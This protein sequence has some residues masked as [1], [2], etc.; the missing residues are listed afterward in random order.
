MM[1]IEP[2]A[3]CATNR[4]SNQLSYIRHNRTIISVKAV[5]DNR[6][7]LFVF[8]RKGYK[9]IYMSSPVPEI[10]RFDSQPLVALPTADLFPV[11]D[12][13][14]CIYNQDDEP[15]RNGLQTV[16][17]DLPSS[18][19]SG[20]SVDINYNT[21]RLLEAVQRS[22]CDLIPLSAMRAVK[23]V[24]VLDADQYW[25][26]IG[27]VDSTH[28]AFN[29]STLFS[30]VPHGARLRVQRPQSGSLFATL[31]GDHCRYLSFSGGLDVPRSEAYSLDTVECHYNSHRSVSARM[32]GHPESILGWNDHVLRVKSTPPIHGDYHVE[33]SP[34][35]QWVYRSPD[36]L[37]KANHL[38]QNGSLHIHVDL[39]PRKDP[40][41]SQ[42]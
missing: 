35:E 26:A 3:F 12:M 30:L 7:W 41:Q 25:E 21:W 39:W 33:P 9:I 40:F 28:P 31:E 22:V 4:R 37:V 2:T 42:N 8:A 13:V 17:R 10:I 38:Q 32:V 29:F 11:I 14:Q 16:R 6:A 23:I 15:H 20:R 1:G 18:T 19:D 34:M 24:R 5:F 27:D 36:S